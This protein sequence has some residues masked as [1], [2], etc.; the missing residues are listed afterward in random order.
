MNPPILEDC[1]GDK[2][3]RERNNFAN[4]RDPFPVLIYFDKMV[5]FQSE[6]GTG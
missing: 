1:A 4:G 6:T 5:A 2:N 3:S